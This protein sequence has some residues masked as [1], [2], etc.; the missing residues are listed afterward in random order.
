MLHDQGW[1]ATETHRCAF[2]TGTL[3]CASRVA[4]VS[5]RWPGSAGV[6]ACL[7]LSLPVV[8][9]PRPLRTLPMVLLLFFFFAFDPDSEGAWA[10]QAGEAFLSQ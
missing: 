9:P 3:T 4:V 6:P 2:E 8:L 1:G 5:L 10:S 7:L